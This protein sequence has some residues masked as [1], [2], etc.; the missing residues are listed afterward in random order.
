VLHDF[1]PVVEIDLEPVDSV[2]VTTLMDNVADALTPDQGPARRRGLGSGP[3][4]PSAVMPEG[5]APDGLIA[6]HGFSALVTVTKAGHEHRFV[7]DTGS[8][9]DGVAENMRRLGA[10]AGSIEAIGGG[11]ASCC[12]AGTRW[13]YP[14]PAAGR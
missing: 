3:W 10:D 5:R 7:F 13:R 12:P 14:R 4:R 1:E 6:E 2:V 11:G 9:P 8:S